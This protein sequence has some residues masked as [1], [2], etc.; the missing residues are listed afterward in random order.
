MHSQY[1]EDDIQY[2]LND[3]AN[4]MSFRQA[5]L[6]WGPPRATLHDRLNG[7]ISRAKASQPSQRLSPVQE[8]RLTDWVLVQKSIRSSLTHAQIRSFAGRILAAKNDALPLGKRWISNFLRRNPILKTKKQ[9]KIDFI[10]VNS[11]TTEIIKLWFQKLEI[12]IIKTIKPENRW[13]IN[14][15]RIMENIGNNRLIVKSIYKQRI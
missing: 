13:N 6:K 15:A 14:K 11:A 10:R 2:A 1:T 7:R 4:G 12:F 8:Q 3:I 5:S 9:Y